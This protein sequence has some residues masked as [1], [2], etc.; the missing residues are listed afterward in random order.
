MAARPQPIKVPGRA[1]VFFPPL[2]ERKPFSLSHLLLLPMPKSPVQMC[3]F[4]FTP[5]DILSIDR[6]PALW[7]LDPGSQHCN[8]LLPD[9]KEGRGAKKLRL[10]LLYQ[11]WFFLG[12]VVREVQ[13]SGKIQDDDLASASRI[14]S[15]R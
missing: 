10:S 7:P 8:S 3:F 5:L 9:E 6:H 2:S 15:L 13:S 12:S 11:L 1:R 4:S 14:S